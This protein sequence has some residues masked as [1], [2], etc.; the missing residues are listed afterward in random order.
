M[1]ETEKIKVWLKT[2]HGH[3]VCVCHKSERLCHKTGRPCIESCYC[4]TV[5]RD[6]FRGWQSTQRNIYGR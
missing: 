4:D 1:E 5:T 6:K 2:E 3:T